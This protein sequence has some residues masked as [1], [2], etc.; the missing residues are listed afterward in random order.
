[1]QN[2]K[3]YSGTYTVSGLRKLFDRAGVK[4]DSSFHVQ[5]MMT[6][7]RFLE[8]VLDE[9]EHVHGVR[10][11]T[12]EHVIT[13]VSR[14]INVRGTSGRRCGKTT[15]DDCLVFPMTRFDSSVRATGKRRFESGAM[16]LLQ[17]ATENYLVHRLAQAS[18]HVGNAALTR[19]DF[20]IFDNE[21]DY[22][23]PVSNSWHPNFVGSVRRVYSFTATGKR[24]KTVNANDLFR[25]NADCPVMGHKKYHVASRAFPPR[26]ANHSGCYGRTFRGNDGRLYL[27][28]PDKN[29]VYRWMLA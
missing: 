22:Y 16:K 13:A 3:H 5:M 26:P 29:G 15:T 8:N 10:T 21:H 12:K 25:H 7:K 4:F 28:A 14:Q 23:L 11:I 1:M 2:N 20:K 17:Q 27:S 6:A 18:A 9:I 19:S 24:V